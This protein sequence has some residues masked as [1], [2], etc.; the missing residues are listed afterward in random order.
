[1]KA[2]VLQAP[3]KLE[4][5]ET[6][7]LTCP[8]GGLLLKTM[9]C[10]IC[11]TDVKMYLHGHRD[12]V[13]PR[14]LGHEVAGEV[15][16]SR[17]ASGF[18]PG[19]RVQLFPGICCGECPSCRRGADNQCQ[20][21]GIIGFNYDG[22]F[23][24]YIAVPP[25]SITGGGVNHL[26]DGL[27]YEEATLAEPLASCI[28]SQQLCNVSAGDSVLI[29][30]AG[31][32]GQLQAL[33]AKHNGASKIMIAEPL[34]ARLVIPGIAAVNRMIDINKE[35][36]AKV[37]AEE[38]D[39]RGADV[40]LAASGEANVAALPPLLAPRGR[41]CLFSGLPRQ[42]AIVPLDANLIH[43]RELSITGAYGSTTAQNRLAVELIASG[44]IPV[45]QLITKRFRLDEIEEG[46]EYTAR[47]VGLKA[48]ITFQ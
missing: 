11:S 2:A 17:A 24:E 41:L 40:I 23:A 16:E 39:G 7:V 36:L 8:E 5:K 34:A 33:L 32:L 6:E 43:Y 22:G 42:D 27:S 37:V 18:K 35:E 15:V 19:D 48:M 46:M 28:N 3:G 31:P 14:I 21:I 44:D 20:H 9:A 1:M 47:R 10:S 26:P 4:L 12:L 13:Y 38:T 45:A 30:G 25:Q 29:L